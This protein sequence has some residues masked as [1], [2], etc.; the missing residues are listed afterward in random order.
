LDNQ[1][2]IVILCQGYKKQ[3]V[4]YGGKPKT[5]HKYD[6]GMANKKE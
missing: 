3:K 5:R 1:A 4:A 6:D 2:R